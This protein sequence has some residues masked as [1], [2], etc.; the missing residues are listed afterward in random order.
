[1]SKNIE[2]L[3]S[4]QELLQTVFTDPTKALQAL[5]SVGKDL[6]PEKRKQT[7]QVVFPTIIVSSV[8]GSTT[9]MLVRG[10]VK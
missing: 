7:Q 2:L 4:P 8:I 10:R 6:T 1:E 3:Q 5:S 9:N